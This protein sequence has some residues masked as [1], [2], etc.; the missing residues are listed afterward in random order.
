[1][2]WFSA[3]ARILLLLACGT[4]LGWYFGFPLIGAALMLLLVLLFWGYL[5]GRLLL[6]LLAP[7]APPADI[8]G[9]WGEIVARIYKH[10]RDAAD[11][12]QRLQST[13]DY[14]LD[15]FASMRDGVAI[16]ER[17]GGIRWCNEEATRLLGLR[18]P[19]DTG[20]A[21]TNLIR[22]PDFTEY[23]R[24]GNYV[25]P[26]YLFTDG[27]LRLHLQII[28]TQFGDGD[29]L[30]FARDVTERLKLE[31]MRRD[32]VGN[33]SHELRTPLTVI[34]GYLG[35]FL[36]DTA[37]LPENYVKPVRQM[38][39]Q[40]QRMES[41]IKDLLWLSRIESEQEQ[42]KH[43]SINVA[44]LL[45]ELREELSGT[46]PQRKLLLELLCKQ[47]V[48][49][50]YRQ[51]YSAV[52]NLVHNAMKY[53]DVDSPVTVTWRQD[54]GKCRLSV[55]DQGI[56]I[57]E[58]HIPRLTERFYRVD[59]SRNSATGGTGL[60]LAIV[61]HV[62]ASHGAALQVDSTPGSGSCF[63]LVFSDVTQCDC[64]P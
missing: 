63:S 6:W 46:H 21:I 47:H 50:D 2:Y 27:E 35:T 52:S 3:V 32:F 39:Q 34:T 49:G 55:S 8:Q 60:G 62:A 11:S 43:E 7:G 13:V 61:K 26:L 10:Q 59:D 31:Q 41:M 64:C 30:L 45:E 9:V 1:M 58:T 12:Q 44:A 29:S 19:E 48:S 23:V 42:E 15:S 20:Q 4:G 25:E 14:L 57:D 16:I 56:G 54:G 36:G 28:I 53:S 22:Y 40:A 5:L 33:V 24:A 37:H 18:F 51:L 38:M 17:G